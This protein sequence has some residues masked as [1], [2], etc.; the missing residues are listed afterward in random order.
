[1][2][3]KGNNDH[4]PSS[5]AITRAVKRHTRY[6]REQHQRYLFSLA[7]SK[8]YLAAVLPLTLVS[9]YLTV[10][11]LPSKAPKGIFA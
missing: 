2:L 1:M 6:L 10:S 11:A 7:P 8:V 9:S 5:H 3:P 4:H